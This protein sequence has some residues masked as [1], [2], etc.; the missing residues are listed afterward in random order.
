MSVA[1]SLSVE[2]L[3]AARQAAADAQKAVWLN[4][5]KYDEAISLICTHRNTLS[6]RRRF[7]TKYGRYIN[8]K[9]PHKLFEEIRALSNMKG[10]LTGP[11]VKLPADI[12]EAV[13]SVE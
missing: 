5:A 3:W 11:L 6:F 4:T 9:D 7:F 8:N 12:I 1:W 2:A 13:R 10:S